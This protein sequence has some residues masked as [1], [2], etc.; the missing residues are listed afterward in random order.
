MSTSV[1]ALHNDHHVITLIPNSNLCAVQ[2][3]KRY[4]DLL[5]PDINTFFQYPSKSHKCFNKEAIGNNTLGV[6][7]KEI[8]IKADL[9]KTLTKDQIRKTTATGFRRSSFTLVQITHVMKHKIFRLFEALCRWAN[10]D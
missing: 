3:Y 9:S 1:N 10:N 8:S 7:M 4:L 5:H 2:S 6:L